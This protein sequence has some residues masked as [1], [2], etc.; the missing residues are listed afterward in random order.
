[1]EHHQDCHRRFWESQLL[2]EHWWSVSSFPDQCYSYI[3]HRQYSLKT[4]LSFSP[5]SFAAI[6]LPILD[7][8][9]S[10]SLL[11]VSPA[12]LY[13]FSP[14]YAIREQQGGTDLFTANLKATRWVNYEHWLLNWLEP[15]QLLRQFHGFVSSHV[16]SS[17]PLTKDF[18]A[19]VWYLL[20]LGKHLPAFFSVQDHFQ[21]HKW[22]RIFCL[23]P[24]RL[25]SGM[26]P[27]LFCFSDLTLCF[28][29][30][31]LSKLVPSTSCPS[32]RALYPSNCLQ[33]LQQYLP[34]W[35]P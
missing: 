23:G 29:V 22:I 33:P 11:D 25:C 6:P 7:L 5:E 12:V 28:I 31:S 1:M 10:D 34:L 8:N 3:L 14:L 16:F 15:F 4:S 30:L 13:L 35:L 19:L 20:V 21:D 18:S 24:G 27:I 9:G 26:L 17:F 2:C 32:N